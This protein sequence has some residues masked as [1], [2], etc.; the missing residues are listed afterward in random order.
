[1]SEV[2]NIQYKHNSTP[3]TW[4]CGMMVRALNPDHGAKCML[5][6]SS[7]RSGLVYD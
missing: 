4:V 2:R 1:M 7:E 3:E 5:W 6:F